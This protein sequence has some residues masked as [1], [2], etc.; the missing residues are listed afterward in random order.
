MV[1]EKYG[2]GKKYCVRCHPNHRKDPSFRKALSAV[3]IY[4]EER[5]IDFFD[6]ESEV[7]SHRLIRHAGLVAVDI[8]SIAIDAIILGRKVD[9]FGES[10]GSVIYNEL[11]KR[12]RGELLAEEMSKVLVLRSYLFQEKLSISASIYAAIMVLVSGDFRKAVATL[13]RTV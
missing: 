7:S 10:T 6:P 2:A 8:S 4:C 12:Y 5:F 11:S 1:V 9:F 3:K 13:L